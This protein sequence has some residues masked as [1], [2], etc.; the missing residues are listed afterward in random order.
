M[1]EQCPDRRRPR[2]GRQSL[3]RRTM[4]RQWWNPFDGMEELTFK[5]VEGGYL[6]AAPSPWLLGRKR[7]YFVKAEQKA[8]LA[9]AHRTTMRQTFWT[10]VVGAGACGPLAGVFLSSH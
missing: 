1:G 3:R 7:Y 4:S 9:A 5:P 10:I 2:R 8:A 6:Y